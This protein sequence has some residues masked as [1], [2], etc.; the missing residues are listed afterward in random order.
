ARALLDEVTDAAIAAINGPNS[1]VVSGSTTTVGTIVDALKDRGR[2]ATYLKVSHAFHSPL[3]NPIL[4]EFTQ[5]AHTLHYNE[6]TLPFVSTVTGTHADPAVLASPEYW[7]THIHETVHFTDAVHTLAARGVTRYVEIGPD[8]V[9]SAL[10]RPA[11]GPEGA[12]RITVVPLMRGRRDESTALLTGVGLLYAAGAGVDWSALYGGAARAVDLPTY[13]FQHR[14][15]WITSPVL[16]GG[17]MAD[18]TEPA[19][20]DGSQD[21]GAGDGLR[22]RLHELGQPEREKLLIEVVLEHTAVVLGRDSAGELDP[23]RGFL[24]VGVDS[25]SATELRGQLRRATGLELPASAVFD[26]GTPARLAAYLAT[27]PPAGGD[28]DRVSAAPAVVESSGT[29][30]TVSELFRAAVREGRMV[31][32]TALLGAVAELRPSFGSAVGL[33]DRCPPVRL[34]TGPAGPLL[35]CFPSPM[36]L[37]GA[38]QYARLA[39]GFRDVREVHVVTPPGFVDGEPLPDSVDAVVDHFARSVRELAGDRSFALVGYSSGGQ[40]AHATAT[41]LEREGSTPAGIVLLDT[42]LP[43]DGGDGPSTGA[44]DGLWASMLDGMMARE[45][46]FGTFSTTRLSAMGRYSA[47]MRRCVP[48]E[49]EAPVLFVR[50]AESFVDG[51]AGGDGRGGPGDPAAGTGVDDGGWRSS[52][53]APHTLREVPGNHFTLLEE[54]ARSTAEAVETWMRSLGVNNTP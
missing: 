46:H 18:G 4:D 9:L 6:P 30:E 37:A 8:A 49:V 31:E 40:F 42:Y 26:L 2:K 1:L 17:V 32:G 12:E 51:L 38:Q 21:D 36:A 3:M 45:N 39:A 20:A 11:L 14:R 33:G 43:L 24:D 13:P 29:P 28:A 47:L 19:G 25:L 23:E 34:A 50:P 52:W 7:V 16:F 22:A 27:A 41:R 35:I 48:E 5:L 54:S 15:Y 10:V 53:P 44:T